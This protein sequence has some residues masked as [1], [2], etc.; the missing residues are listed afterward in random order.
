MIG[1]RNANTIPTLYKETKTNEALCLLKEYLQVLFILRKVNVSMNKFCSIIY[2]FLLKTLHVKYTIY[3]KY[4]TIL[5]TSSISDNFPILCFFK[6]FLLPPSFS[7]ISIFCHVDWPW[8]PNNMAEYGQTNLKIFR[9]L[10]RAINKSP[11]QRLYFYM[12]LL[13]ISY[14]VAG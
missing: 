10:E 12:H 5:H 13:Y 8:L 3:D 7:A 2:R 6:S 9:N 1:I 14:L 11:L 4:V